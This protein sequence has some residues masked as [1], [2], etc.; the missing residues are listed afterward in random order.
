MAVKKDM[1]TNSGESTRI[2]LALTAT[3]RVEKLWEAALQMARASG[4]ELTVLLL[5]DDTWH[6]AASLPFTREI[7]RLG[8]IHSDF[9]LQRAEQLSNDAVARTREL[10]QTLANAAQLKC[11]FEVVVSSAEAD[12]KALVT[13]RQ[14]TVVAP[15][16]ITVLPFY[17]S[18]MQLDCK[19]LL[20]E[21]E[22]GV[23]AVEK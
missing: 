3:S 6:R 11:S 14:S 12:I 16:H 20:V 5:K 19:L 10:A 4:A 9:T 15:S 8:G 23:H 1:T 13:G 2:L 17:A 22:G 7:S 18:L 21:E